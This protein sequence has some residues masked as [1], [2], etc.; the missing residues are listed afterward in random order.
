MLRTALLIG[1]CLPVA[2][3][4]L[5]DTRP[6]VLWL[7]AEDLGPELSCYGTPE[8][9][10]PNLDSL[11]EE[12]VRFE[13]AFATAPVCS[14]SRSAFMTG[15]NAIASGA[16]NHR[17]HRDDGFL[18]PEGVELVTEPLRR[19]G[20]QVAN[21]R[22]L[23]IE[24]VR[25]TG[26][27][28]WN[29]TV[30]G[31]PFDTRRWGELEQ[32][33]FAQVNFTETHRGKA[34]DTAH[35]RIAAPADPERVE[36]PPY[37]P[38]HPLV[39]ADWAQYLNA[40]MALDVRVGAVLAKLEESGLASTTVVA[41]LGDHGRAMVRGK[42]WCYDSGLRVPLIVRWPSA[43]DPPEGFVAGAVDHRLVSL[44]DVTATTI[45]VLG[46]E[47]PA[48][49]HGRVLFGP[50]SDPPRQVVYGARDRCDETVFRI[51][52]ARDAR[53]RYIRN[54]LPERPFLQLNR[55]KE[56]SYPTLPLMRRL[57]AD[58]ELGPLPSVLFA[59]R[60]PAEELYDLSNDPWETV[61]LAADPSH[62]EVKERLASDLDAWLAEMGDR[63]AT[64]EPPDV[65]AEWEQRMAERYDGELARIRREWDLPELE[66]GTPDDG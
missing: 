59:E 51:R 62:T 9:H 52:T 25:G 14:A 2:A 43:L 64:L 11:A 49:F 20:V 18:L 37:Y 55:Y 31:E 33:F 42:Q 8:V 44:L 12:G 3:Q 10:T 38:D 23:G 50:H 24:G 27:T 63:G 54:D 60:R 26:K 40:V 28:D 41:F 61:N 29:F 19:A 65:V 57:F 15:V 21:L 30:E 39:R 58:G 7:I 4:E 22:E 16:H 36:P 5:H 35:E 6:N 56:R 45:A 48:V 53:Y 34:W 46:A 66:S 32:P 47:E 17:S 13:L 1:T